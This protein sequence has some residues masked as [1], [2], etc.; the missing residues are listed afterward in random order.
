MHENFARNPLT[1]Y[2]DEN[3]HWERELSDPLGE[4]AFTVK[5]SKR[6]G[7]ERLWIFSYNQINSNFRK[8][9]CR[10]ARGIILEITDGKV[11]R[12]VRRAFDKFFNAREGL[13]DKIDWAS[14]DVYLSEKRDGSIM[15][16]YSYNGQWYWSTSGM[17]HA[18]DA[19]MSNVISLAKDGSADAKTYQDLIDLALKANPIDYGALDKNHTYS[20]ELTSPTN[21]I[22]TPYDVT[23]LTLI[24]DRDNVTGEEVDIRDSVLAKYFPLPEEYHAS[25]LDEAEK[26]ADELTGL[27]EGFVARGGPLLPSGSFPRAKIKSREYVKVHH[28]RGEQNFSRKQLFDVAQANE[29]GELT[30]YYPEL[31][32]AVQEIVEEFAA[33]RE[34]V[35]RWVLIAKDKLN[36]LIAA[37][38]LYQYSKVNVYKEFAK[39]VNSPAVPKPFRGFAFYAKDDGPVNRVRDF[40]HDV[41]WKDYCSILND[42]NSIK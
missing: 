6:P 26:I 36:E 13:A 31:K 27:K 5:N 29:T 3:K 39:Y 2:I 23:T 7:E 32:D 14:D 40:F 35:E 8:P 42:V 28:I 41:S 34:E 1:D 24:G 25:S 21:R 20:L 16:L 37:D 17:F 15:E 33:L 38:P 9:E 11:T 12:I 18:D 22:V 30:A 4:F 10:I 19:T